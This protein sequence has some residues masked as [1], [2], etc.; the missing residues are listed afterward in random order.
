[1][2][3]QSQPFSADQTAIPTPYPEYPATPVTRERYVPQHVQDAMFRMPD[4]M[5]GQLALETDHA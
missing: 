1:M 5:R 3:D 2:P 4:V